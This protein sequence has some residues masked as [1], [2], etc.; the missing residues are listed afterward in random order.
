M[1]IE[2]FRNIRDALYGGGASFEE[3]GLL[4]ILNA[5]LCYYTG[6]A[7]AD[8]VCL[9]LGWSLFG[10]LLTFGAILFSFVV[11]LLFISPRVPKKFFLMPTLYFPT[12]MALCLP[13]FLL[14]GK[15]WTDLFFSAL[16]LI[17]GVLMLVMIKMRCGAWLLRKKDL[18]S[19]PFSGSYL[20]CFFGGT[21]LSIIIL[22]SLAVGSLM[23]AVS[24]YSS[25]FVR[26]TPISIKLAEK[27]YEKEN[28]RVILYGMSH[29]ASKD[30]Y[31]R[32]KG[33]ISQQ[34]AIIL[35]EGVSDRQ[36][37]IKNKSHYKAM[38][39]LLDKDVQPAKLSNTIPQRN[40]D[41]DV[42][43]FSPETINVLNMVMDFHASLDNK[44][45]GKMGKF[46]KIIILLEANRK[47]TEKSSNLEENSRFLL[48]DLL[49]K[50]NEH[51]LEEI[52]SALLK[53]DTVIVPWGVLHMPGVEQMIKEKGFTCK[54]KSYSSLF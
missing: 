13:V 40:A 9:F 33:K 36:K 26:I 34:E 6:A 4:F 19:R 17:I 11:F 28:K 22:T 31:K 12:V 32:L 16:Q 27:T 8:I 39:D 41:L 10:G 21:A 42:S 35:C 30:F 47:F 54:E 44:M 24:H 52:S 18:K 46:Q 14:L 20:F 25:D 50:R 48:E 51:L 37:L 49:V 7:A 29:I 15:G 43:A 38:A 2:L 1:K 45:D 23:L 3:K 53:Y 5:Y